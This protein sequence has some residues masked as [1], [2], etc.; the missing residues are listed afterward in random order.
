MSGLM[1]VRRE[2]PLAS[3]ASA[4]AQAIA[5]DARID[6]S[7]RCGGLRLQPLVVLGL[8]A[9]AVGDL[10]LELAA[11]RIDVVAAGAP[12]RRDNAGIV[13]QLLEAADGFFV[14]AL[15][16][17]TRERVER[18]QVYLG[19]VLHLQAAVEVAH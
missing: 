16:A 17:R 9:G 13:E 3:N 7:R 19:R 5:L 6:A 18:D 8:A 15:E 14:R 11:G 4:N 10:A 12:H 2:Q 1:K